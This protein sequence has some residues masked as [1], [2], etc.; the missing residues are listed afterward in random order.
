MKLRIVSDL[1]TEFFN[2]NNFLRILARYIPKMED[3]HNTILC[4][5]GDLGLLHKPHTIIKP[6]VYLSKRFKQVVLVNGN[7]SFYHNNYIDRFNEWISENELPTNVHF[8]DDDWV[9]LYGVKFIGS[10]L[11]TDIDKSNP[12]TM[13]MV[14]G[15][16]N[17]YQFI[18]K[19]KLPIPEL[20]SLYSTSYV[21]DCFKPLDGIKL[22]NTSKEFIFNQVK[23][24]KKCVVITHHLPTYAAI[25][26][27]Y[28]GDHISPAYASELSEGIL[29]NPNIKLWIHG[30]TH[31]TQVIDIGDTKVVCNALGYHNERMN[32]LY[33][34][35]LTME[36]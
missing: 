14:E 13:R 6:L 32:K 18:H 17:D 7:H 4:I 23:D 20:S 36:I 30:H 22:F 27:D 35:T 26:N 9:E 33:D 1:H 15:R 11:W 29:D 31:T 25:C 8:L 19:S 12:V 10:V 34:N 3:D 28:K 21:N 5:A 16:M 24:H 2:Y